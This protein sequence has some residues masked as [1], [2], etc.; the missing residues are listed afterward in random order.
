MSLYLHGRVGDHRL[1]LP[2]ERVL[3]VWPG[4]ACESAGRWRTRDLPTI[5]LRSVLGAAIVGEPV[6]IAYGA[7]PDDADAV[8]LTLDGVVGL[9]ALATD[10]LTTLPAISARAAALFDAVTREPVDTRHLLRLKLQ[11]D[12]ASVAAG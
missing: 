5:D 8:V 4:R 7:S 11:P 2:A 10:A 1:L 9:L 6:H 12:F 3:E